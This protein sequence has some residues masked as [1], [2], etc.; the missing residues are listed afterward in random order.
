MNRLDTRWRGGEGWPCG[1]GILP[2]DQRHP[3]FHRVDR[4][5][6]HPGALRVHRVPHALA[7]MALGTRGRQEETDPSAREHARVRPMTTP[8]VPQHT[9]EG[10][11][12]VLCTLMENALNV[13]WIQGGPLQNH[14][15]SRRGCDRA[16]HRDVL[17]LLWPR[18]HGCDAASRHTSAWDRQQPQAPGIFAKESPWALI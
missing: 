10:I 17:H 8:L 12:I 18:S 4:C 9:G 2:A 14:A 3:G 1:F 15:L 13:G 11:L 7:G 6:Q 5:R 16:L